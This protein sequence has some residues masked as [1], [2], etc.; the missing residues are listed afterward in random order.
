MSDGSS[1]TRNQNMSDTLATGRAT[2][3][4]PNA[5]VAQDALFGTGMT[6]GGISSIV[7][8][9]GAFAKDRSVERID[10]IKNRVDFDS[11]VS[12]V[13][14]ESRSETSGY[15][16]L[17]FP[18]D[19]PR[20]YMSFEFANYV[21]PSGFDQLR[22]PR[23]QT[24]H[25]PLPM[26]LLETYMVD[27]SSD[28]T[29]FIGDV[30]RQI[31]PENVRNILEDLSAGTNVD[32]TDNNVV[33]AAF[34][35]GGSWASRFLRN[36]LNGAMSSAGDVAQQILGAIP[37]PH[38]SVFF[39]GV[40]MRQL[41]FSWKL[42][43]QSEEESRTMKAIIDAFKSHSLPKLGTEEGSFLLHY[44]NIVKPFIVGTDYGFDFKYGF[45]TN[46]TVVHT[47]EEPAYYKSG[48]PVSYLITLDIME[49]EYF[50]RNEGD[51]GID[52]GGGTFDG[53]VSQEDQDNIN[54]VLETGE[55]GTD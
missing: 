48:A 24:I 25:L 45:V 47:P 34:Q 11:S 18:P 37:N 17:S 9:G 52:N 14:A 30:A 49:I 31:N 29:N 38:T 41:M 54:G 23:I 55:E 3:N 19:L 33:D 6:A 15:P 5:R 50:V 2:N 32:W 44:P 20:I 27:I 26:Q 36:R 13:V 42:S 39:N 35:T 51:R 22:L 8:S 16:D 1:G 40:R 21:R 28:D 7:T 46:I 10:D 53:D 43:P 12:A 4:D